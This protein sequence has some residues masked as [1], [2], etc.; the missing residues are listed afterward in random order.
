MLYSPAVPKWLN[1]IPIRHLRARLE[2][3]RCAPPR[4]G[5]MLPRC[6]ACDVRTPDRCLVDDVWVG[7]Y[8]G[9]SS[10]AWFE[11]P[12]GEDARR[13]GENCTAGQRI[14]LKQ[15]HLAFV[16]S[17]RVANPTVGAGSVRDRWLTG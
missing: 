4:P 6:T 13:P 12:P 10:R 9:R 7:N 2:M 16:A 14:V 1:V 11:L 5:V 15:Q 3:T 17:R 8:R